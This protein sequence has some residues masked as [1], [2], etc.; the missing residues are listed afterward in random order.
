MARIA[1]LLEL[2]EVGL[3]AEEVSETATRRAIEIGR[4]LIPHAQAAFA[5]LGADGVD[6]DAAAIVAWIKRGGRTEFTRNECQK[7]MPRFRT[8]DRLTKALERLK[9]HEAIHMFQRKNKGARASFA[10]LV[11]PKLF[12]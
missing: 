4:L 9:Q 10:C 3:H 6:A 1:G 12:M 5:L 8:V 2:A 7:E 11:N